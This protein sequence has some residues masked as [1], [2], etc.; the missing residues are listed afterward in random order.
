MFGLL[1][2]GF[3]DKGVHTLTEKLRARG[4]KGLMIY[5]DYDCTFCSKRS[6]DLKRFLLLSPES[7]AVG[8][9][10]TNPEIAAIMERE[11]SWVIAYEH[12]IRQNGMVL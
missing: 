5:Y 6:F 8:F 3:W 10:S 2:E 7:G 1:P 9:A 11:N 4:N 12:L